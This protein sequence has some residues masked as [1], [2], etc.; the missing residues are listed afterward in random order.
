MQNLL[1][2][3]CVIKVYSPSSSIVDE[4]N[5]DL[6]IRNTENPSFHGRLEIATKTYPC[7]ND[8]STH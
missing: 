1:F 3:H 2:E 5:S 7:F 4:L 8:L 6:K